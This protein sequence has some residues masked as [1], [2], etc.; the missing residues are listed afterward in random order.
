MQLAKQTHRSLII[1]SII[2]NH[3]KGVLHCGGL[4]IESEICSPFKW[5]GKFKH[6]FP[7]FWKWLLQA[8]PKQNAHTSG[9]KL[10][11][12]LPKP[13]YSTHLCFKNWKLGYLIMVAYILELEKCGEPWSATLQRLAP[14]LPSDI[15]DTC[16]Y[17]TSG[18]EFPKRKTRTSYNTASS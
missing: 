15:G 10:L 4:S 8:F 11:F 6:W 2:N 18:R 3:K 5:K 1:H 12:W 7:R 13:P 17:L 9:K 14:W 16:F